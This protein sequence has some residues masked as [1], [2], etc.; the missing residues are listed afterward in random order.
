MHNGE[1]VR[2]QA[3]LI[4]VHLVHQIDEEENVVLNIM[5]FARVMFEPAGMDLEVVALQAGGKGRWEVR[6]R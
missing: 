3:L 1:L 4:L 2:C 5:F 6:E